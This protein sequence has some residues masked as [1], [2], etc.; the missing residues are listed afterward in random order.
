MEDISGRVDVMYKCDTGRYPLT[1]L[2]RKVL[3]LEHAFVA[4]DVDLCDT[5]NPWDIPRMVNA[6]DIK[7]RIIE[8]QYRLLV[9]VL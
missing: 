5:V 7:K 6:K 1:L 9:M 4:V 8:L 2:V 3:Q